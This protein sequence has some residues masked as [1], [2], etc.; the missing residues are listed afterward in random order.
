MSL[1]NMAASFYKLTLPSLLQIKGVSV[2][3]PD[4]SVIRAYLPHHWIMYLNVTPCQSSHVAG[5][6]IPLLTKGYISE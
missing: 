3:Q 4:H 5:I 2:F 6:Q 1:L